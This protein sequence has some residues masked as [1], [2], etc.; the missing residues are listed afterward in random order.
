MLGIGRC[1]PPVRP[2]R[3][4]LQAFQRERLQ[5]VPARP[6]TSQ[7]IQPVPF[8]ECRGS[9]QAYSASHAINAL[10]IGQTLSNQDKVTSAAQVSLRFWFPQEWRGEKRRCAEMS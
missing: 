4:Q 9:V 3:G 6:R 10:R 7:A 2:P 5:D 1:L 8:M